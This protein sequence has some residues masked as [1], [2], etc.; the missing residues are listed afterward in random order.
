MKTWIKWAGTYRVIKSISMTGSQI[1]NHF[2]RSLLN[3]LQFFFKTIH[4]IWLFLELSKCT[5]AWRIIYD[6]HSFFRE[7]AGPI[8]FLNNQFDFFLANVP[9]LFRSLL[10]LVQCGGRPVLIHLAL[11]CL[12]LNLRD[13]CEIAWVLKEE[14]QRGC[15]ERLHFSQQRTK[16]NLGGMYLMMFGLSL[17]ELF[18]FWKCSL[19]SNVTRIIRV[20]SNSIP[21][22]SRGNNVGISFSVVWNLLRFQKFPFMQLFISYSFASILFASFQ[23]HVVRFGPPC[24]DLFF[25]DESG[26]YIIPCC[27][28]TLSPS[29]LFLK[30]AKNPLGVAYPIMLLLGF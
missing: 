30:T 13:E 17:D 4:M 8:Y 18:W 20:H 10:P 16:Y 9:W 25:P 27:R 5:L 23:S 1:S 11:S 7:S 29:S 26:S 12:L 2:R 14:R 15:I 24:P 6:S 21:L 28:S 22:Y 19:W 3:S